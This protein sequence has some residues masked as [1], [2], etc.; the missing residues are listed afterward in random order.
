M[1]RIVIAIDGPGG[2][3]K[4]TVSRTL[5]RE[6]GYR[7]VDTGAM[8]RVIGVLA[9]EQ[10]IGL[11]DHEALAG[12]CDR[13]SIEFDEA[14][15]GARVLAGGRDFTEA[16]R[17]A[18]AAQHASRYSTVPAVRERLVAKQRELGAVGGVVMEGR[19]IG[20]V[21]FPDAPLKIF[22]DASPRERARRRAADLYGEAA[23][24]EQI[25]AIERE[26]AERDA[27][28]SGRA[29]SPLRPAADAVILDTTDKPLE[30]VV[31][32]LRAL[33]SAKDKGLASHS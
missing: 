28:D 31:D 13:T 11:G 19:D 27:R 16:I 22:L 17:T 4:S 9:A 12:L 6:L 18:E 21:V 33:A 15:G 7:Y 2:A 30:H 5:A 10:G 3:G 25:T 23:N 26:I 29:H 20:T 14:G 32:T 8:Y 1:S 24:D